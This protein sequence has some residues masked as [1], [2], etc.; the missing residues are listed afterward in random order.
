MLHIFNTLSDKKE[1]LVKPKGRVL[2]L[3]VCGPT[4]YN[5]PHIGNARTFMAFDIIV[6]YL[7]SEGYK[8]FYLQNIT[9]IDDKIIAKAKEEKTDWQSVAKKYERVFY[10]NLKDLN[11]NSV[12]KFARATDYIPEILKQVKTL[13]KKGHAY[14]IPGDGWYFDLKTFPNYGKLTHRTVGQAEDGVSRID[15]SDKKRNAGDFALWKFSKKGEPSWPTDL[16]AGR[17]G[18]HIE[19]TAISEH[20]FGPQYDLHGG[21]IDLK[22]PHHEAE[23]AQQESASGKKPFV[24]VWLHAGFLD[25]NGQKMAKSLENFIT[26]Q[27]LLEKYPAEIFRMMVLTHHYRSPMDYTES[28]VRQA[29]NS[30]QNLRNF[31]ARLNLIKKSG[32]LAKE[33]KNLLKKADAAFKMA[34][35]DDFNTPDA[36]A[37][38]FSLINQVEPKIWTLT[39]SEVAAIKDLLLKKMA[40]FGINLKKI[41][42]IPPK[43]IQ[44]A[45]KRELYRTH[46]QF[47]QADAL[48]KEIEKL[49][50][51]IEDTPAG[52]MIL[53]N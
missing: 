23:I 28:L 19:D 45:K 40:I 47:A 29:E 14:K 36:L 34:M 51:S 26:I 20:F 2:K 48:R 3:F 21:A 18:W 50:Y 33:T 13:V 46:K 9:D 10:K 17:P 30:L 31:L 6:R 49:G 25:I 52:P 43:I 37:A 24:K 11:I 8:I 38:L 42:P 22:F 44:I 4:V 35:E 12:D 16:G 32:A 1:N 41:E 27:Q 53:K 7:R 39:K 5:Y 15:A